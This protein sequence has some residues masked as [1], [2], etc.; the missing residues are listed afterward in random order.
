MHQSL[1]PWPTPVRR[2]ALE[3][4]FGEPCPDPAAVPMG[5]CADHGHGAAPDHETGLTC[6]EGAASASTGHPVC[7][8][9]EEGARIFLSPEGIRQHE[10]SLFTPAPRLR[11][12]A[13]VSRKQT[14]RKIVLKM[15][16][17]CP[18]NMVA[19]VSP[20]GEFPVPLEDRQIL[21]MRV[22]APVPQ[23][24]LPGFHQTKGQRSLHDPWPPSGTRLPTSA[25]APGEGRLDS[26]PRPG[27][28]AARPLARQVSPA[29]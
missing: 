8:R 23:S 1:P 29:P 27:Q 11:P 19:L 24:A 7:A 4:A 2:M 18:S 14:S 26:R 6:G 12:R 22:R 5:L 17:P 16:W 15:W 13:P 10:C 25:R 21:L 20:S 28:P 3:K 9:P